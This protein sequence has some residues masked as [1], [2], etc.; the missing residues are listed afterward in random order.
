MCVKCHIFYST[1]LPRSAPGYAFLSALTYQ[2][3]CKAMTE[4]NPE[5]AMRRVHRSVNGTLAL[6]HQTHIIIPC[7]LQ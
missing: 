6:H 3:M 4:E 2:G 5:E 7:R 1:M